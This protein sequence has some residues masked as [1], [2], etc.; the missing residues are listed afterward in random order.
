MRVKEFVSLEMRLLPKFKG[1]TVKGQLMLLQPIE[2]TL[3]G[4]HFDGSSFD[5]KSVY[6]DVFFMPLC[7]PVEHI[8]FTFGHRVRDKGGDR[9]NTEEPNFQGALESAMG[10]EVPSLLKLRTP[11]DVANALEPL[12]KP[13]DVG[14]VNPHCYEAFAYTLLQAGEATAAANVIDTLLKCVN[15]TVAWE[16]EIA[17]RA[18]LI[19]DKLLE[20]PARAHEQLAAWEA[21]NVLN[22]GLHRFRSNCGPL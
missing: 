8:H 6:V 13:N 18:R 14:Y 1:F 2:H 19:K 11:K 15:P 9:W 7:V 22:F 17:C 12:T 5:R 10:K 20:Q 16:V 4:F 3:R 21:E